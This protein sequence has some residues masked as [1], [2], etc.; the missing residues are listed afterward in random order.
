M[1]QDSSHHEL[2]E[3]TQK[4]SNDDWRKETKEEPRFLVGSENEGESQRYPDK[5]SSIYQ[6]TRSME[7]LIHFKEKESVDSQETFRH[8]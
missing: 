5:S 8:V 6:R 1:P 3:T 2:A 4:I 7:K